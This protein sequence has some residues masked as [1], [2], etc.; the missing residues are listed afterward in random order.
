MLG[1]GLRAGSR[2]RAGRAG[3][4]TGVLCLVVAGC[5][6]SGGVRAEGAAPTAIPWRGTAYALDYESV[7]QEEPESFSPTP[8]VWL[9]HLKWRRWGSNL[10]VANGF[11][12]D[13]ACVSGCTEDG[14][15]SYRVTLVLTD[16]KRRAHA[17]YYGHASLRT[18]RGEKTPGWA[19]PDLDDL[20]LHVPKS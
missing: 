17:A 2:R 14:M 9:S 13:V 19:Q 11:S 7:P 12:W 5:G 18:A 16:L 20:V 4:L 10:A 3:A 1:L 6:V 15:P 8:D